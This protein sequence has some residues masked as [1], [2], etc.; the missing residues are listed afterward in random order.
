MKKG[1]LL[2][3]LVAILSLAILFA[4]CDEPDEEPTGTET[5][6]A[7]ETETESATEAPTDTAEDTEINDEQENANHEMHSYFDLKDEAEADPLATISR[8]DGEII[9]I[10][11]EHNLAAVKTED[12][13]TLNNVVTKVQVYDLLTGEVIREDSVSTPYGNEPIEKAALM[14]VEIIY[15]VIRIEKTTYA[16][17]GEGEEP[18]MQ[19]EVSYYLARKDGEL[20]HKTEDG[21]FDEYYDVYEYGNGLVCIRMGD[22]YTWID[23][24]LNII[25][26][27]DAIVAN[28][29]YMID[30][31]S[32]S[33]EYKGYLYSYDGYELKVFNHAGVI[34]AQYR[35]SDYNSEINCFVLDNGNVLVQELTSVKYHQSCDFVLSGTRYTLKSM[36]VNAVSGEMTE[37]DLDFVVD[38]LESEYGQESYNADLKLANGRDNLAIVYKIANGSIS[39]YA[40][41]YVLDN[42][43]KV[44]YTVKNET[45]GVDFRNGIE[46]IGNGKY[47]TKMN[48][49]GYRWD[50]IFD[51][52][53]NLISAVQDKYYTDEFIVT[54]NAIYNYKM[55]TVFDYTEADYYYYGIA[56]GKIYLLADNFLTGAEEVYVFDSE[57]KKPE[58]FVDGVEYEV[59]S[60]LDEIYIIYDIENELYT[61]YNSAGTE[62]LVT[63]EEIDDYYVLDG[64]VI[65]ETEFNG[66][67]V[68]YIIK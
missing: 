19:K 62:L 39:A 45:Y 25:R 34:S 30:P 68:V 67:E 37:V 54:D 40:D 26:S 5:A 64:V 63:Y 41:M 23:K 38:E 53:G 59:D 6:T 17:K 15:P 51:L 21:S 56:N 58:L 57:T 43:C 4:A 9:D 22:K 33:N 3:L 61:V 60:I 50:A 52:D 35:V 47:I 13:D 2:I 65:I 55:E 14:D 8:I 42:D 18:E 7:T 48:T 49:D 27:V 36:I 44:V 46:Y 31:D 28:Y 20:V 32:F 12:I 10:D 24:G 29:G 11:Y 16:E 1:K 66:D